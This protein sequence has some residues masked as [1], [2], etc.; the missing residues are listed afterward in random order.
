MK[1][2]KEIKTATITDKGQIAIPKD[3]RKMK[4]FQEGSKVAILAYDD[5][6]EIR[7]M[8]HVSER[9]ETAFASERVLAKD[10]NTKED[11]AAWKDL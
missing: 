3:M 6:I 10:W 4:G 2:I 11:D 9:M 5:K 7:P 1:K 8:H